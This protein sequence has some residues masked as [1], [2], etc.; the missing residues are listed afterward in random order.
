M[1]KNINLSSMDDVLCDECKNDTFKET[2]RFKSQSKI[3]SPD[4]KNKLIPIQTF[5][6]EKCGHVNTLFKGSTT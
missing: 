6:C 2:I 5:M 1:S 4:G 3:M